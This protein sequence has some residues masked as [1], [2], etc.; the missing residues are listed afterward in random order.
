MTNNK[1][2]RLI[3]VNA[4]NLKELFC[5]QV[6]FIVFNL[7]IGTQFHLEYPFTVDYFTVFRLGNYV[8]NILMDKLFH[9]FSI[10]CSP[11]SSVRTRHGFC[12]CEWVWINVCNLCWL[13]AYCS[14]DFNNF[15]CLSLNSTRYSGSWL[16]KGLPIFIGRLLITIIIV[17]YGLAFESGRP[18]DLR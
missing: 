16:L 5:N 4:F 7:A 17:M 1:W 11:L 6:S 3:K 10:S 9:F 15:L 12:I 8:K 2:V 14:G 13:V 18:M